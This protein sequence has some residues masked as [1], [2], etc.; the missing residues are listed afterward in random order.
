[1]QGVVAATSD[2]N[3]AGNHEGPLQAFDGQ[4][5]TKWLTLNAGGPVMTLEFNF[6]D[7]YAVDGISFVTANA[8]PER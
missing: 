5:N 7:P 8:K 6:G 1:M 4:S 3:S 2:K